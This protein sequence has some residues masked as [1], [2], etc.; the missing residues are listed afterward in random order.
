MAWPP[1]IHQD[2]EDAITGLLAAPPTHA[3]QVTEITATGTRS[4]TTVLHGD[5]AWRVPPGGTQ[6]DASETVKGVV[7]LATTAEATAGSD[8]LKVVTPAALKSIT[9]TKAGVLS[10]QTTQGG[11]AY[12][13]ALPDSGTLVEGNNASATT[14]TVPPNSSVAFSIGASIVVRQYGAGQITMTPGSGVTL[15]SR[16]AALKTAGQY[17]ELT[18]TK[19]ATDEWIVT[20]D[21][22]T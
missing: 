15:R 19:R 9:D 20:G 10:T 22:T 13:L 17:A 7:Q 11:T 14:F 18:L 3:H 4:S 2:A 8:A 21:V 12:V 6:P 16:G 5:G 1:D